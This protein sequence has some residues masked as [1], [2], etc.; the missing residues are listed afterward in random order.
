MVCLK[1]I[2][3]YSS[4]DKAQREGIKKMS[5][6][7]PDIVSVLENEGFELKQK[8]KYLWSLCPLHTEK[9]PSFKVDSEKQSFYCFGCS[10]GGDVVSFI[11]KYKNLSFKEALRYLGINGK[12][13]KPD[14]KELKKRELLQRFRAWCND[15]LSDLCSLIRC[16]WKAKQKAKTEE[17]VKRL[18]EFYHRESIW[19]YQMEILQGDGDQ[20]KFKLYKE[21]VFGN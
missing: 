16:L 5:F 4:K 6:Q 17:D 12:P 14:T 7:K 11:Q 10:F 18:A 21:A 8:G 15:Y 1:G 19:L 20:A 2:Q 13:Y 3:R 9:H